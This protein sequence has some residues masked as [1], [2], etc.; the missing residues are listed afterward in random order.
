MPRRRVAAKREI[1]PDPKFGNTILAKFMNH[2]MISGKKSV[3]EKIVYGALDTV[4]SKSGNDPI[5]MFEQS[6]EAIQPMVEVKS[7]RVGGATYQV[8]VEVRPARRQALAMRWLVDAARGRGEKSMAQRLA[9]EMIEACEGKGAA[10][11]KREDVHRMAEANKA[12]SH[13]RF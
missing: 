7:R 8:P 10:V 2:V 12:F 6:L 3:A 5:E 9:N 1:L 4:A 13:Y 11:K